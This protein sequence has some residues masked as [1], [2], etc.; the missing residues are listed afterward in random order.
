M[1]LIWF[2]E[3][4]G[5]CADRDNDALP[6]C[7]LAV[8]TA[9]VRHG[10]P[11]FLPGWSDAWRGKVGIGVIVDRLGRHIDRRFAGRYYGRA[12]LAV[13]AM[14]E[15]Q[16]YCAPAYADALF[17][18]DGSILVSSPFE[19][20]ETSAAFEAVGA[21]SC[22]GTDLAQAFDAAVAMASRAFTL[23]TGDVIIAGEITD[24]PLVAETRLTFSIGDTTILTHK[25]K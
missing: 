19:L 10:T 12:V 1:K 18:L 9:V 15:N 24:V 7:R 22:A 3:K 6:S 2:P 20:S 4:I 25:I 5:S 11:L 13:K 8:E 21:S 16:A 23:H 17:S 14:P